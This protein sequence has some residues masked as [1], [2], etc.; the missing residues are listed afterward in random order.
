MATVEQIARVLAEHS[1]TSIEA[2]AACACGWK[3]GARGVSPRSTAYRQHV[4]EQIAA[5]DGATS[6]EWGVLYPD[7]VTVIHD[8]QDEA[9]DVV[10]RSVNR[11]RLALVSRQV[12][13]W[14]AAE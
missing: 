13:E 8:H 2:V 4:A 9:Q 7:G 5:L 1:E 12:T 11:A 3:V 6:T 10:E 14:R